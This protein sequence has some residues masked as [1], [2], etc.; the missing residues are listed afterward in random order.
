MCVEV[1]NLESKIASS[2]VELAELLEVPLKDMQN[3]PASGYESGISVNACLC[4]L[5]VFKAC[6]EAGFDAKYDEDFNIEISKKKRY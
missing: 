6:E 1:Y 2:V 3:Y 4:Q 5:D